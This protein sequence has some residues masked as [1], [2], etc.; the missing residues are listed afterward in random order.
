MNAIMPYPSTNAELSNLLNAETVLLLRPDC[1][2]R[3]RQ[4]SPA[5]RFLSTT[6]K[7]LV[8]LPL[9]PHLLSTTDLQPLDT[10]PNS[11]NVEF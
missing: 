5:V 10:L 9:F 11:I 2:R 1:D 6:H 8:C 7:P 3:S 4:L